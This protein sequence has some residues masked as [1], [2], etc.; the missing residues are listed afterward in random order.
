MTITASSLNGYYKDNYGEKQRPIPAFGVV[1]RLM[2]FSRRAKTGKAYSEPIFTKRAHGVT[3]AS[4]TAKTAYALAAARSIQSEEARISG[5]EIVLRENL[6]YGALAA[7]EGG[8]KISYGSAFDEA[9]LGIEESHRFYIEENCLYGATSIGAIETTTN[10]SATT[11]L[12]TISKISWAVGLWA[13]MENALVDIYDTVGGTKINTTG[14]VT[15]TSL[16]DAAARKILITA[17]AGDI[18]AIDSGAALNY[19][20]VFVAASGETM[21]GIDKILTNTGT[22]FNIDAAANG[23]WKSNV[24]DCGNTYLTMSKCLAGQTAAVGRG[25]MG[26]M[27]YL[28]NP[29]TW[30]DVAEDQAALR[31][32]GESSVEMKNG[33][34]RIVFNGTGGTITFEQH[35]MVK[36][37]DAFGLQLKWW[38]RGGESDLTVGLQGADNKNFFQEL[39]DNAGFQMRN[40]SS[41]FIYCRKPSAQVKIKNIVPRQLA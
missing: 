34:E 15:I 6:A 13:Q 20:I 32:Y 5:A 27:T 18:T 31:R 30:Q 9:V 35:P 1:Q 25:G 11:T 23:V 4:T 17:A 21:A 36:C 2:P 12:L 19:V 14:S 38:I 16:N 10:Q 24:I 40:F 26:A 8:D 7:S 29:I 3:F 41:Q 33:A 39:P 28:L 22:L 37:G